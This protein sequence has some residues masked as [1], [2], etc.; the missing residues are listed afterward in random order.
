MAIS[1]AVIL[2]AVALHSFFFRTLRPSTGF[3]VEAATNACSCL[4]SDRVFLLRL[5]PGKAVTLNSEPVQFQRPGEFLAKIY[6]T[7]ADKVLY[8][9]ADDDVT[10][11]DVAEVLDVVRSLKYPPLNGGVPIP[12]DLS[13][14]SDPSMDV[15]VRL[16]TAG[17]IA[18]PCMED[19][20]NWGKQGIPL[21]H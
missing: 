2:L 21:E 12:R 9:T 4:H 3:A 14:L 20:Y 5:Y 13:E 6:A 10:F 1:V 8:F 17:A 11:Q 15:H 18:T 7:R 19:C 16:I